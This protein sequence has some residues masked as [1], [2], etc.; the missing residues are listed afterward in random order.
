MIPDSLLDEA[1]G[2]LDEAVRLRRDIHR[3]PELDLHNPRTQELVLDELADIGLG[4]LVTGEKCS[5][6]V[7]T[8]QGER[9]GPTILLRADTDALPMPED[10]GLEYASTVDG[11]MHA[12]GHDA[13]TAMLL[14]AARLLHDRRSEIAGKIVFAFQPGEEGSG[15]AAVMLKEGLIEQTGAQAAFAI[16]QTPTV[17]SGWLVT[18]PG[19]VLASADEFT[20][21]IRGRGGHASQPHDALD[22]IPIAC[23]LVQAMQTM[24]T[25]KVDAFNPAV[26]TVARIT[27]GTTSNVIPECA[28]IEGT[29]RAVSERTRKL[30]LENIRRL[31]EG[32]ASAHDATAELDFPRGY[33][34]T[35]NDDNFAA[36]AAG[37]CRNL[38]SESFVPMPS[39]AMGAEDFSYI[40][41]KVPG[42]MVF[43]GTHPGTAGPR[44][45]LAMSRSSPRADSRATSAA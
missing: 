11:A 19:P 39:P 2:I 32:I 34:V 13:H 27:A 38:V 44:I 4:D 30:V 35:V 29:V 17:P 21:V 36:F 33:P 14:G 6:V 25:R 1:G 12:C 23:E 18:K 3:H 28:E 16:H 40:L 9:E 8:L 7:A 43:L 15:G 37:V 42:A 26:V 31:A 10:T 22:P 20:I 24:V 5:S 41:Q 45:S